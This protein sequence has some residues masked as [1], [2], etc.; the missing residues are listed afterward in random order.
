MS[1]RTKPNNIYKVENAS[2]QSKCKNNKNCSSIRSGSG[3]TNTL[4]TLFIMQIHNASVCNLLGNFL[5]FFFNFSLFLLSSLI[6]MP[7]VYRGALHAVKKRKRLKIIPIWIWI[8]EHRT[9]AKFQQQQQQW[10][11]IVKTVPKMKE[12]VGKFLISYGQISLLLSE[13]GRGGG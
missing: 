5:L 4:C 2:Q 7:A 13:E 8:F 10:K 1:A 12:N 9:C 6:T 11:Q 3:C